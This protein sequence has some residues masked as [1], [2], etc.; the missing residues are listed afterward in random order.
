MFKAPTQLPPVSLLLDDLPTRDARRVARHL[1][2]S[3]STINRYRRND[4]APRLVQLA[5]FFETRWGRSIMDSE[6]EHRHQV[7]LGL[8]RS[9]KAQVSELEARVRHLV[10]LI[11]RD[12]LGAANEPIYDQ[13]ATPAARAAVSIPP[14]REASGSAIER[15]SA[16]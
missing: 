8:V 15:A 2:L 4:D 7:H 5:L 12:G 11:N 1:G 16:T 9:L 14:S 3:V 10:A 13:M 6:L